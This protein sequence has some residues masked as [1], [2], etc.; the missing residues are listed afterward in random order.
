MRSPSYSQQIQQ[1]FCRWKRLFHLILK[2][3]PCYIYFLFHQKHVICE[4]FV[5]VNA[6]VN[7]MQLLAWNR[8][9]LSVFNNLDEFT[10]VFTQSDVFK[11]LA[12]S[13]DDLVS[14]KGQ[15]VD[16]LTDELIDSVFEGF[17]W[18]YFL[19]EGFSD[20]LNWALDAA[21][22][23]FETWARSLIA[24]EDMLVTIGVET[25]MMGSFG[26]GANEGRWLVFLGIARDDDW[27]ILFWWE[28]CNVHGLKRYYV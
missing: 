23:F 14:E 5:I 2:W 20:A 27:R 8:K 21:F 6:F 25:Y 10:L 11:G 24:Q 28:L 26:F 17:N 16:G 18:D 19:L 7:L 15:L 4:L 1:F 3:I 9:F 12:S 13:V 22:V